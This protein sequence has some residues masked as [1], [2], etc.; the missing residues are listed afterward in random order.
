VPNNDPI[1]YD[2]LKAMMEVQS[3]NTEQMVLVADRLKEIAETNKDISTKAT[4]SEDNKKTLLEMKTT[5]TDVASKT[6][7][8]LIIYSALTGLVAIAFLIVQIVNWNATRKSSEEIA[9]Q[10]VYLK[11]IQT[12]GV[13]RGLL[14]EQIKAEIEKQNKAIKLNN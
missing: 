8:L 4:A 11:K 14:Q 6:S 9:Q 13:D 1:S 5:L 10:N 2:Q 7:F 3:K 12:E